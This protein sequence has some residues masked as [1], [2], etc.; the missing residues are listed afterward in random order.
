[1]FS[2]TQAQTDIE[3][4]YLMYFHFDDEGPRFIIERADGSDSRL[5]GDKLMDTS[6]NLIEGAGWSPSGEW[7]AWT[8]TLYHKFYQTPRKA[9]VLAV[10][11]ERRGVLPTH[12]DATLHWAPDADRLLIVSIAASSD[13]TTYSLEFWLQDYSGETQTSK[14]LLSVPLDGTPSEEVVGMLSVKVVWEKD[15]VLVYAYSFDRWINHL[16][17]FAMPSGE[18]I[19]S[20]PA[21]RAPNANGW[22]MSFEGNRLMAT[23]VLMDIPYTFETDTPIEQIQWSPKENVGLVTTEDGVLWVL[24]TWER[25]PNLERVNGGALPLDGEHVFLVNGAFEDS[26]LWSPD[27]HRVVLFIDGNLQVLDTFTQTQFMLPF[28]P[29]Q[30]LF[31]HWIDNEQFVMMPDPMLQVTGPYAVFLVNLADG[32]TRDVMLNSRP[33]RSFFLSSDGAYMVHIGPTMDIV[34]MEAGEQVLSLP[35]DPRTYFTIN[36][37]PQVM[38]HA[39]QDYFISDVDALVAGG[40]SPRYYGVHRYDGTYDRTLGYCVGQHPLCAF[41]L[42]P[43]VDTTRLSAGQTNPDA[44]MQGLVLRQQH[45]SLDDTL[46]EFWVFLLDFSPDGELL[47]AGGIPNNVAPLTVYDADTLAP[48]DTLSLSIYEQGFVWTEEG[49]VY[50]TATLALPMEY[51]MGHYVLRDIGIVELIDLSTNEVLQ[52]FSRHGFSGSMGFSPDGELVIVQGQIYSIPL[53]RVIARIPPD[54]VLSSIFSP[55][56]RYIVVGRGWYIEYWDLATVLSAYAVE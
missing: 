9:Y 7:F 21:E 36:V 11:G 50:D 54:G 55:D 31:T 12:Y 28:Q 40:G 43:R 25:A 23:D 53:G 24:T 38:P 13:Q 45:T 44:L 22:T 39:E 3:P 5:F 42:P 37:S 46:Q 35:P 47:L 48:L 19:T 29:P 15:R 51:S 17:V 4:P 14:L 8:S 10:D 41:W 1:L 20:Q 49:P 33:Q 26:P 30:A 56:G 34:D 27:E 16:A 32:S 18:V 52:Q 2:S 6:H